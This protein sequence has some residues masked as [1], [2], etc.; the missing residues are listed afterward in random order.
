MA[1]QAPPPAEA[2]AKEEEKMYVYPLLGMPR[3]LDTT[4]WVHYGFE[5]GPGFLFESDMFCVCDTDKN[6]QRRDNIQLVYTGS[7]PF[8]HVEGV[9]AARRRRGAA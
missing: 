2:E 8:A 6:T 1:T 7:A 9:R 3:L 4:K 5:Y